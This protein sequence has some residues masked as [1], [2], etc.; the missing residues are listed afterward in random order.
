LRLSQLPGK[1]S[2]LSPQPNQLSNRITVF[3]AA[4]KPA[5]QQNYNLLNLQPNQLPTKLQASQLRLN[6]LPCRNTVFPS[7]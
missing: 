2:L 3:P 7:C 5:A 1:Y 4:A 6:Q